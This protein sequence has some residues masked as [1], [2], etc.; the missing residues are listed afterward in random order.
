M[1][2]IRKNLRSAAQAAGGK[3]AR[4]EASDYLAAVPDI[5]ATGFVKMKFFDHTRSS[6]PAFET[7]LNGGI[8]LIAMLNDQDRK[9]GPWTKRGL[10]ANKKR[11]LLMFSSDEDAVL[12]RLLID[13]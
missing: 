11:E 12:G 10:K 1:A 5:A 13:G 6:I 9:L 4:D 7:D 2:S 3:L 8:R